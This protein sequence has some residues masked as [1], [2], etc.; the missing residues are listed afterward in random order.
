MSLNTFYGGRVPCRQ[1]CLGPIKVIIWP[2]LAKDYTA[3]EGQNKQGQAG[4]GKPDI[5]FD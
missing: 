3:G 1:N 5:A 4:L 2:C